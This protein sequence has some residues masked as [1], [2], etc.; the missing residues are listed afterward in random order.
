MLVIPPNTQILLDAL[1][2]ER[3]LLCMSQRLSDDMNNLTAWPTD[4]SRVF[5]ILNDVLAELVSKDTAEQISTL[6]VER[7]REQMN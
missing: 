1:H 3:E 6:F 5:S 4:E 2:R 7:L